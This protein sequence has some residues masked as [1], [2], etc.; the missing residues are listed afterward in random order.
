MTPDDHKIW[1]QVTESILP[2]VFGSVAPVMRPVAP[3]LRETFRQTLDLHGLTLAQAH[4][5]TQRFVVAAQQHGAK[6]VVIITGLSGPIRREF[7]LWVENL[8]PVR[9]L[10]ALNGGGAFRLHLTRRKVR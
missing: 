3:S 5:E 6:S 2:L 9:G 1:K 10:Q 7:P 4:I 8:T